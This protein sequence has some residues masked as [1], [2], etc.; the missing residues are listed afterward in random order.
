VELLVQFGFCRWGEGGGDGK[1]HTHTDM[2]VLILGG[3]GVSNTQT[4]MCIRLQL[5]SKLGSTV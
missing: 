5:F 2:A 4:M 1:V 3:G